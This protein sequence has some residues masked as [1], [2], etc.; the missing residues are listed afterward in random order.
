MSKEEYFTKLLGNHEKSNQ[1]RRISHDL[2]VL[3]GKIKN[4]MKSQS[5]KTEIIEKET[6]LKN[7]ELKQ[8]IKTVNSKQMSVLTDR[9][10]EI[11]KIYVNDVSILI[12]EDDKLQNFNLFIKSKNLRSSKTDDKIFKLL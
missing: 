9:I 4:E 7:N 5:L 1:E 3:Y 10:K 8:N 11:T 12:N 6:I 2:M